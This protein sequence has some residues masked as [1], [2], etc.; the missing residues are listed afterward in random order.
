MLQD[1]VKFYIIILFN[2]EDE[3]VTLHLAV[4]GFILWVTKSRQQGLKY[5]LITGLR[6]QNLRDV[7]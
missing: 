2:N 1:Y 3:R 7:S 4:V 6:G 5:M